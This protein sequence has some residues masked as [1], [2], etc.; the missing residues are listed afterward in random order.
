MSSLNGGDNV[1]LSCE[2]LDCAR[3]KSSTLNGT[4]KDKADRA[5]EKSRVVK[6]ISKS[7]GSLGR[8]F[9]RKL[10]KMSRLNG[11]S[12][13]EGKSSTSTA[14]VL[15]EV[16]EIRERQHII[17]AELNARA[18]DFHEEMVANY[19]QRA[20]ERFREELAAS[21]NSQSQSSTAS[22]PRDAEPT[23]AASANGALMILHVVVRRC[24]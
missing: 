17:A 19:L 15:D 14:T 20:Q 16:A 12:S 2:K 5:A 3:K 18:G 7:F 6:Q 1:H 4:L 23:S 10:K 24:H 22:T 21:E 8:S 11:S 13:K 9:S